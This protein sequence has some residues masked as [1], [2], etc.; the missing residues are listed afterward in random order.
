V[1]LEDL[2]LPGNK[3]TSV[4]LEILNLPVLKLL[5]L[6]SNL[7]SEIPSEITG[8]TALESLLLNNNKL[9]KINPD[10]GKLENLTEL[11]LSHNE[12]TELPLEFGQLKKIVDLDISGNLLHGLPETFEQNCWQMK[13][14]KIGFNNLW[15]I[16]HFSAFE[17]AK[18]QET[19][20]NQHLPFISCP[21]NPLIQ[22]WYSPKVI[23]PSSLLPPPSFLLLPPSSLLPPLSSLLFL[24]IIL[25]R[26]T[27]TL[28]LLRLTR[29]SYKKNF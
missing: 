6:G 18:E 26:G 8:L 12:I 25:P 10:L 15:R 14:L 16:P 5:C 2:F 28:I 19:T 3:Y 13:Q 1:N 4:P 27:L 9:A 7:I 24:L 22:S 20:I 23:P 29:V 21:S 11:D 17:K